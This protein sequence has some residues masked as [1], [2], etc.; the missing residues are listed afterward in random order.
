MVG[1]WQ[2]HWEGGRPLMMPYRGT[3]E[4]DEEEKHNFTCCHILNN[5]TVEQKLLKSNNN[6]D[7][8]YKQGGKAES[9]KWQM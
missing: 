9:G 2:N 3:R 8:Q 5:H 1:V 6:G 7:V 4:E